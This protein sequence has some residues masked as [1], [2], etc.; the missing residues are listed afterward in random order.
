MLRTSKL[1][2]TKK[3]KKTILRTS[4]LMNAENNYEYKN[5]NCKSFVWSGG[6]LRMISGQFVSVV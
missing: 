3:P 1:M 2:K 6:D 4:K 5:K